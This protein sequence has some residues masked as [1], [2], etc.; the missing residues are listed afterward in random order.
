MLSIAK[1]QLE[2]ATE[3]ESKVVV[4]K[5][6]FHPKE[7]IVDT[8]KRVRDSAPI[9]KLGSTVKRAREAA[10]VGHIVDKVTA[11]A[12]SEKVQTES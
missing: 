5:E 9:E 3:P 10:P 2:T 12:E 11:S 7:K 8:A 4:K 6:G 1:K